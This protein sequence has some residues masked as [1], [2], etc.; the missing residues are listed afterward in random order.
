M[1][2]YWLPRSGVLALIA[3]T[4]CAC[5]STATVKQSEQLANAGVAYGAAA[6]T[7]IE[8]TRDRYLD[9]HSDAMLAE[10]SDPTTACTSRQI[11]GEDTPS[12][13]CDQLMGDFK[14]TSEKDK[15]LVEQFSDLSAQADALGRYFQAL[16]SLATYDAKGEVATAADGILTRLNALSDKLEGE[17]RLSDAQKSA[18]GQLA[19]LVGDSIKAAHLRERLRKDA[20]SIG[21]AIDIQSGV[22]EAN[23]G[24]LAG[25]DTAAREEL[26]I[27]KV[28]NPYLTYEALSN[29]AAWRANRRLAL[30]PTPEIQQ[31]QTLRS[32]SVSLKSVW[33]DILSGRGSPEAAQQVFD[34]IAN[35][36]K[37][38]G[39][40]RMEQEKKE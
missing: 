8:L 32:A 35:A 17:A 4:L 3:I 20:A 27:M 30:L 39:E 14:K 23:A 18:W 38:I 13:A 24:L 25:M 33:E 16:K 1:D 36:L 40:A 34:D 22:L 5:A 26:F 21:R 15:Q 2:L 31:L 12:A 7:V 9:W 6:H 19:G 11:S 29:P 37:L 28:E 10:L